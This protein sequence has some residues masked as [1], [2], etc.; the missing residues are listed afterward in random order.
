MWGG[1]FLDATFAHHVKA[2]RAVSHQ[3]CD[4][5]HGCKALYGIEIAAVRIP[6]PGQSGE[7]G[8]LGNVLYG[9]HHAGQEFTVFW[10]AGCKG[11]TAVTE[12][13]RGHPMPG[14]RG[15][16]RVPADLC[17]QMGVHVDEA[18]CC[19]VT[20]GIDFLD[21][22]GIYLAQSNNAVVLDGDVADVRGTARTVDNVCVSYDQVVFHL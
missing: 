14:D 11:N 16:R 22:L 3:A 9:F 17:I 18:G 5:D 4:V 7:N 2:D 13:G 10:A 12:Q 19:G 20:I 6:V 8:L 15:E 1:W 21:A